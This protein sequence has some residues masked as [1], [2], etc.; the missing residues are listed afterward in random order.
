MKPK[1]LAL[2]TLM[3]EGRR[4]AAWIPLGPL[5]RQ[6]EAEASLLV[7]HDAQGQLAKCPHQWHHF[8]IACGIAG[9]FPVGLPVGGLAH[10]QDLHAPGR[11]L[12]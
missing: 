1:E 10:L 11:W 9:M 5:V 8:I 4:L 2:V 3:L 7:V 12:V 6:R